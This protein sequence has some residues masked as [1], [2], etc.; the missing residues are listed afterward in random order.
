MNKQLQLFL[1]RCDEE[2]LSLL[3]REEIA[4]LLFLDG[5]VWPDCPD[6]RGSIGQCDTNIVYLYCRPLDEL[7]TLRRKDGWLEGPVAGCVIQILRSI[8]KDKILLSE[9]VREILIQ[10]ILIAV[11]GHR[12]V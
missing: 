2:Q 7:P 3:L 8:E 6:C 10:P 4:A 5:N 11:H 12:A 9:R 1:T